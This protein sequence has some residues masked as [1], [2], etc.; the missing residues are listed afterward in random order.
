MTKVSSNL[1]NPLTGTNFQIVGID[2]PK[3]YKNNARKHPPEQIEKLTASIQE[4][5]QIVP[6]IVHKNYEIMAGH[7]RLEA[8]KKAGLTHVAVICA[9]HLTEAQKRAFI[10]A[11]NRLTEL[12]EW[13]E[14]ILKIELSYIVDAELNCEI[15][16]SAT[17]TGFET[18]QIDNFL[19]APEP[20]EDCQITQELMAAMDSAPAVS[21]TGDLWLLGK[22]KV[23][24]GDSLIKRNYTLLM[25][26]NQARILCSDP[27]YNLKID[28]FVGGKGTTKHREFAEAS[29]EMSVDEFAEFLS[30]FLANALTVLKEGG[31]AY[32]FMDWRHDRELQAAAKKSDL[33]QIN[34]CIW[35]KKTGG[36]G[37]F[38]RSQH[39]LVFVYRRSKAAHVNNI[40]LGKHGRNRSNVWYHPSANMSGDGRKVLKGHPTPKPVPLLM[41][42]LKDAS[43]T[44]D[45]VLDPFLG[46]GSMV[47]AAEKTRRC[48][49]GIEI[50]P[51]YVD[52]TIRRWQELTGSDAIHAE[53]GKTFSQHEK[54]LTK[55]KTRRV[56]ERSYGGGHDK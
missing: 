2:K 44:G 13:D 15:G 3:P 30:T 21:K 25:G 29:G 4:F 14:N 17:V 38:Y 5:G 43:K 6:I 8:A 23:L 1:V 50:D 12:A 33:I 22:H 7:A 16:F 10:I 41:D 39:E 28:G 35:D 52:L 55:D 20:D 47:L 40:M 31:L 24:C 37:S 54:G 45:I 26:N 56:R 32:I 49:H 53:T 9:D 42:I 34:L 18:A 36:M 51:L 27:P 46:S 11:D 48:C 19:A